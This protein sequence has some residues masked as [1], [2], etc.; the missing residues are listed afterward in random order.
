MGDMYFVSF[1]QLRESAEARFDH[2]NSFRRGSRRTVSNVGCY[3]VEKRHL[4]HAIFGNYGGPTLKL[5]PTYLPRV[6]MSCEAVQ[7]LSNCDNLILGN[8]LGP[9]RVEKLEPLDTVVILP[10]GFSCKGDQTVAG[11]RHN[12]PTFV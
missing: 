8:L 6:R 5:R 12:L 1:S 11:K 3:N 2:S 10:F 7:L 9:V 4:V